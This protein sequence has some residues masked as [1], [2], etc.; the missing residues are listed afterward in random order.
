M[1]FHSPC[2]LANQ[3]KSSSTRH[4]ILQYDAPKYVGRWD[5]FSFILIDTI[6]RQ[7]ISPAKPYIY[8]IKGS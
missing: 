2:G 1:S 4:D 3:L 5:M 7:F 6:K 8:C